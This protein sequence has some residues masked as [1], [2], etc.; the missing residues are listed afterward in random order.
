MGFA[1]PWLL[2]GL[3]A[4]AAPVLVHLVLREERTGR[5]FPSLMF[6]RRIPFELKRRRKLR[7]RALLALRCVA[8]AAIVLAFAA[9]YIDADV[10]PQ[11]AVDPQR[12][13]VW[14]LDRSYS[15]SHPRRWERAVAEIRDRIEALGPGERAALVAFDDA[16]RVAAGLTADRAALRSAL[17]RVE[18]GQGGTGLAAAFGAADRI[19]ARSGAARR[20]V[21]IVSDLQRSALDAGGA[22]PLGETVALEIVPVTQ[23]VG[24]NAA[25]IDARLAPR[26][27]PAVEDTL[28]VRVRNTGDAALADASVALEVD[29]RRAETRPLALAAGEERTV[30]FPVVLAAERPT[31]ITVQVG[32]DALAAD[33]RYHAVLAPRRPLVAALIE[34]DRPRAHHG[35]FLE[36][37]LRLARAPAVEVRRVHVREIDETLL[38]AVD[39]VILDDVALASASAAQAVSMFVARGG[40]VLITAGPSAA[41][42]GFLAPRFGP[43]LAREGAGARIEVLTGDHPLWAAAGLEG[44]HALSGARITAAR[45]LTPAPDDRVLARLSDGAPLL[46][47]HTAGAGRVL[48]LATTADPRW[49]TLVLEPGFVPFVHAVAAHLGGGSGWRAAYVAGEVVDLLRHAGS[50]PGTADWR[51]YLVNGGAVVVENPVGV[52]DRVQRPEGALFTTR[53]PGIHEAHRADGRGPS[54][55][56]AV[57]VG[58]AESM[59]AA[60]A[61]EA[62]ERRI[63]RRSGAADAPRGIAREARDD[64]AAFGSS[65]WLLMLAGLALIIE[66]LLA[67]RISQRR[68]AS[69]TGARA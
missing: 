40:G 12:D 32:P 48:A 67:N 53:V 17:A 61:P 28:V 37:A 5:A 27:E 42:G 55:P 4:L 1:N 21:V 36:E 68:A 46:L 2:L 16:A 62:L 52:P 26:R 60:A 13:V 25:V 11:S 54:L 63:V 3:A 30:T 29:A 49:G 69:A 47:E 34:P 31:R 59:L 44:R 8:L 45:R 14:L 18:P 7:D 15:M 56:F 66:S 38:D 50:L 57:N 39:V 23:P 19:L 41:G 24:A 43:A 64:A 22:L 6:V 51:A 33:D 10:T 9:P 65:W 20:G 35:V 58:R